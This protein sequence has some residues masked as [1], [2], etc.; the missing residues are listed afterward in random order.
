[1]DVFA[2]LAADVQIARASPVFIQPTELTVK[3]CSLT[4]PIKTTM[5][6]PQ[7]SRARQDAPGFVASTSDV[8]AHSGT[9]CASGAGASDWTVATNVW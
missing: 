6:R 4:S 1:M 7:S 3:A 9:D 5:E 8:C 2:V